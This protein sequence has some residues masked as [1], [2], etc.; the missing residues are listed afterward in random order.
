MKNYW[1]FLIAMLM[2]FTACEN[3]DSV[4]NR[5]AFIG[6]YEYQ[7]DGQVDIFVDGVK[8]LSPTLDGDGM[9]EIVKEGDKNGVA[10]IGSSFA[11]IDSLHAVVKG[12]KLVLVTDEYAY[13]AQGMTLILKLSNDEMPMVDNKITWETNIT[14]NGAFGD[15]DVTCSGNLRLQA[16]K[17]L[18]LD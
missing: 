15:K 14:G 9:F 3:S 7:T 10:I 1:F 6:V 11:Q 4:N 17:K 12:S 16:N 8:M 5:D 18:L 2:V 13:N